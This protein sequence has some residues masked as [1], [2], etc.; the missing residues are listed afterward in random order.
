MPRIHER[1]KLI[2]NSESG[3][4]LAVV[5]CTKGLTEAEAISVVTNVL[6]GEILG[7]MKY[8]IRMERHGNTETPGGWAPSEE[9]A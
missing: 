5:E 9:P 4:R 6:S 1:E 7:R 8:A 3:L 2:N